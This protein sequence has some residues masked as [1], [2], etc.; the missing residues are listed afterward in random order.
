MRRYLVLVLWLVFPSASFGQAGSDAIVVLRG[1][2]MGTTWLVRYV[3]DDDAPD[4]LRLQRAIIEELELVNAQM[5]TW[6][7]DSE[8]SRFNQSGSTDWFEVSRETA[9]VVDQANRVSQTSGG[10]FDVTVA[11][12]V[13]LWTFDGEI[14]GERAPPDDAAIAAAREL[15]GY[16]RLK[17][18][19]DSPAL[20]KA[21]SGLHINLS[22]IAKGH[23]VDRIGELLSEH[24]L[25]AW[26]VEIG[27]EV[28]AKGR[29]PNGQPWRIGIESP[30]EGKRTLQRAL[31]LDDFAV[32]TSGDYRIFFEH[33]G[34]RYSHTIDP[35]TGRPVTHR[36]ASVSVFAETCLKADAFATALMVLGPEEGYNLANEENI[37][38]TFIVRDG[39]SFTEKSTT[40]FEERFGALVSQT[41]P[42][43]SSMKVFLAAAA[44]FAI[45][46]GGM[47]IGVII[48]NRR[49]KGS[50][51]G[52]AGLQ[53][54]TGKT[55]CDM[56]STPS[57]EC[58]GQPGEVDA[59]EPTAV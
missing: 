38:A 43:G 40:A 23:G 41:L 49:L 59:E 51:G 22:A 21:N 4:D 6:Q 30:T 15:M 14:E 52:L 57:P 20:R 24:K 17:A 29:K 5:S 9:F 33:E 8:I 7:A 42:T 34:S 37:S 44:V 48:S 54:Q 58:A 19:F 36:L 16:S 2:T 10:A 46:M 13:K 50:C 28:R 26:L 39:N 12:L 53:D 45:A 35:R 27:G 1:R 25:D 56:C 11:P 18:R 47:A 31:P 3:A 55:M 32:A